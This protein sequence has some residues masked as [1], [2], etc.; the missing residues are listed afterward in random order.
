VLSS[1]NGN[2]PF[3]FIQSV[4]QV[5]G[6]VENLSSPMAPPRWKPTPGIALPPLYHFRLVNLLLEQEELLTYSHDGDHVR[7][8]LCHSEAKAVKSW[9]AR[10]GLKNHLQCAT[11]LACYT[12]YLERINTRNEQLDQLD[13]AYNTEGV[14]EFPQFPPVEPPHLPPMFSDPYSD[15]DVS[16]PSPRASVSQLMEELGQTVQPEIRTA[17]E[18]R[19]LLRQ[20]YERMLEDAYLENQLDGV[21]DKFIGDEMPKENLEEDD[22]ED[23]CFD[24]SLLKNS[25]YLPYPSKTVSA[26][27]EY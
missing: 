19:A 18:T 8:N 1:K 9:I 25:E 5:T 27:P 4:L 15:G 13:G 16:M 12:N 23:D 17:E 10:K 11:H 20:E 6:S 22:D 3:S 2:Q 26:V 21:A 14:P 24:F 7:C